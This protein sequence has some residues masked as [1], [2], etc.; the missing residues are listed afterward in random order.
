MQG[1]AKRT[2]SPFYKALIRKWNKANPQHTFPLRYAHHR[3]LELN[4][5]AFLDHPHPLP[6]PKQLAQAKAD[7]KRK[8]SKRGTSSSA[9]ASL[10]INLEPFRAMFKEV[11]EGVLEEKLPGLIEPLLKVK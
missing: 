11:V 9:G 8:M 5:T 7:S 10:S 1:E 4:R 2:F 6:P 3:L